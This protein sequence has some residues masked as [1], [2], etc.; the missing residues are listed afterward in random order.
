M[1]TMPRPLPRSLDPLPGEALPGYLLRLAHRLE[2][3]PA[4]VTTITGLTRP[5]TFLIPGRLLLQLSTAETSRFCHACRLTPR[6]ATGLCLTSLAGRYPPLDLTIRE[7]QSPP[8]QPGLW[9]RQARGVTGLG[10]WVFTTSARYCPSCLAGD[11]SPVQ[12]R[13]GGP[14]KKTW[15]IPLIF[16]CTLHQRLLATHCPA[17]SAPAHLAGSGAGLICRPGALLHPAQCRAIPPAA[18]QNHN[19]G[20]QPACGQRLDHDN[21]GAQTAVTAHILRLQ[22]RLLRLLQPDGPD[23]VTSIG[24]PVTI[25][26]YLLDLRL[27]TVVIRLTWPM[28]TNLTGAVSF[29]DAI[30]EHV[31]RQHKAMRSL[32]EQGRRAVPMVL[33]DTPPLE[34]RACAGLLDTATRL[35]GLADPPSLANI[36]HPLLAR[37]FDD[38]RC[39]RFINLAIPAC[40]PALQDVLTSIESSR[41]AQRPPSRRGDNLRG[42]TVSYRWRAGSPSPAPRPS[43]QFDHR[44]VPQHLTAQWFERHL[45]PA[46]SGIHPRILRRAAAVRLVQMT[47]QHTIAEASALLEIPETTSRPAIFMTDS[48]A[49]SNTVNTSQLIAAL[50]AIADELE[51]SARPIDYANRRHALR[52][53]TIP[54]DDWDA[55]AT[56]LQ[57]DPSAGR[58]TQWGDRYRRAASVL[59]WL[60][61]TQGERLCAPLVRAHKQSAS[62]DGLLMEDLR[63]AAYQGRGRGRYIALQQAIQPYARQLAARIDHREAIASGPFPG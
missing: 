23:S 34:P 4:Q 19:H 13:H 33:Y 58:I 9:L 15:R 35:L 2:Q 32:A 16:A 8:R 27:I 43:C 53:W 54:P 40:S 36:L 30:D 48:W 14:W 55:I 7:L 3:S 18:S 26:R 22:H 45:A 38:P 17:C 42:S 37:A 44:H 31:G 24:H 50:D 25:A 61:I 41:N 60:Q 20:D 5:R 57:A 6:E 39:I 28:A 11:G 10:R 51:S 1:D 52:A 46:A 21:A 49:R 47:R 59:A 29:A 56:Q 12:Q 62:H 63:Q